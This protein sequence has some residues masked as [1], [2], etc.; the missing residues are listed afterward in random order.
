MNQRSFRLLAAA[1]LLSSPAY[2]APDF[3][4]EVKP[5]LEAKCLLCH[6]T[7]KEKGGLQLHTREAMLKGG[8][9]E[10]GAV[11]PGK[12]DESLLIE[13]ILLDPVDDEIM[14]QETDPLS[15]EEI[16]ILKAWVAAGAEMPEGARLKAQKAPIPEDELAIPKDPPKSVAEAASTIDKL[17]AYENSKRDPLKAE[18]ITDKAFIRRATIDLIGR[19][20][21]MEELREFE[22]W[23]PADR[24][25]KLVAKLLDDPRFADRW[26]VF[27]SDMLRVRS[28]A[29]GGRE[30]LAWLHSQVSQNQ[31]YDKIAHELISASGRPGHN[32]AVG[33]ILNDNADPMSMTAAVGQIFLGTR[34]ACAQCHDHPFDDWNQMEFYEM[35]SFFGKTVRQQSNFTRTVYTTETDSNRVQWPPER[36]NPESREP[37]NPRFPFELVEYQETPHFIARFQEKRAAEEAKLAVVDTGKELEDLIDLDAGPKKK[38][39]FN[40]LGEAKK[41][42]ADLDVTKDLYRPSELR[43]ELAQRIANPKNPYFAR[44]FVNRVWSELNG[45]GFV[46]PLDNFTAFADIKHPQTLD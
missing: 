8:D 29:S 23:S 39:S 27:Y 37:V 24:R 9:S 44:A 12:I 28:N 42:S 22:N 14:P 32:P 43:K 4:K 33:F 1:L 5:L 40:V 17:I 15:T 13:R 26:T 11:I 46:E 35:A 36:E 34:L 3:E 21:S 16:E 30:L 18:S 19:I 41:A 45:R 31:P 6:G 25:E 7:G 20:P 10:I 38:E 2:A